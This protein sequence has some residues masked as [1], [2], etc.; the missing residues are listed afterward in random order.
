[1]SNLREPINGFT[2]II[3]AVLSIVA[4]I[5]LVWR[6]ARAKKT[7]H[8]VAV[9]IYGVSQIALYTMS[10]LYHSL[11]V[12]PAAIVTFQHVEHAMIYFLI[13]GTYTPLCLIILRGKWGWSLFGVNWG[14]AITGMC[15]KLTLRH[16]PQIVIVVL[17]SFFIIMG[18]LIIIAWRPLVKTL[19]KP[20]I[21]WLVAGG[22]FYTFGAII[23]GMKNL[24]LGFGFGP[25]QV[26]HIFVMAGGFCIF[27][28]MYKYVLPVR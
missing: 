27:W 2:H 6:A 25:H 8:I 1:M 18:W 28:L 16:P 13:A 7:R 17:F 5:I 26:W 24:Y 12:S 11:T 21:G 22:L 10:A 20:G 15:L 4:L 19:P 14:L 9:S 23:L 3:G